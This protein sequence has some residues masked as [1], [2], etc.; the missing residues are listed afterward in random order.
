MSLKLAL[1]DDPSLTSPCRAGLMVAQCPSETDERLDESA[2]MAVSNCTVS[3][4]WVRGLCAQL[5][6]A[7]SLVC[8]PS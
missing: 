7:S 3:M 1:A 6:Q 4:V 5:E 2:A 8:S